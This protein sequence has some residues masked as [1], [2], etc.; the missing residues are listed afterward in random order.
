MYKFQLEAQASIVG[1]T[2][3]KMSLIVPLLLDGGRGIN[4]RKFIDLTDAVD[5]F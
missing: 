5:E 3:S 2:G 4:P 1:G